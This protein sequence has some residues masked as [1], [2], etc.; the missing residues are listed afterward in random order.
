VQQAQASSMQVALLGIN[1]P[2][3]VY[4]AAA[5]YLA[6]QPSSPLS[7]MHGYR[8]FVISMLTPALT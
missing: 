7:L 6:V 5:T 4:Q 1:Q 8:L 2:G 3:I